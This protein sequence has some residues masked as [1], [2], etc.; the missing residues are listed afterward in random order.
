MTPKDIYNKASGQKLHDKD[1]E[2][3]ESGNPFI[4]FVFVVMMILGMS[5]LGYLVITL[6]FGG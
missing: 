2:P 1:I 6:F 4:T 3:L 5:A